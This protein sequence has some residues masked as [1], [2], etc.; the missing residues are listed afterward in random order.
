M[1]YGKYITWYCEYHFLRS[2]MIISAECFNSYPLRLLD[3]GS[4]HGCSLPAGEA[5]GYE[6]IEDLKITTGPEDSCSIWL[7]GLAKLS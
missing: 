6:R 2:V 4:P 7:S 3:R 5:E 1:A